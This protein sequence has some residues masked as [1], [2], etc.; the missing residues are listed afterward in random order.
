MKFVVLVMQY[1]QRYCCSATTLRSGAPARVVW[2]VWVYRTRTSFK[3][4]KLSSVNLKRE[5]NIPYLGASLHPVA[6][7]QYEPRVPPV[8]I[9]GY[10]VP[11]VKD[12]RFL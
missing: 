4:L 1:G 9:D 3:R 8:P 12:D 2:I 10:S 7:V 5:K 11:L 6:L